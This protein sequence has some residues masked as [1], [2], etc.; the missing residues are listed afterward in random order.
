MRIH[1]ADTLNLPASVVA[2]GAFDGVH[3]GH[4]KVIKEVV[5]KSKAL[6]VPS[7]V[8]TF[9]PPPRSYFEGASILTPIQEKLRRL[10][11]LQVDHVVVAKFNAAYLA[12]SAADFIL[13]LSRIH[14]VEVIVGK[15][16]RFGRGREGGLVD[17]AEHFPV[18]VID[19][20][21]C[22]RGEVIS[23]TRIRRLISRGEM[24]EALSLLD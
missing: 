8:Y 22:S 14:P 13:E 24:V 1:M 15:D 9:D 4:Q 16:F 12:R 5:T 6:G 19:S 18:R 10:F 11:E 17:L 3:R 20:V 23:S 7:V 2:I 21:C